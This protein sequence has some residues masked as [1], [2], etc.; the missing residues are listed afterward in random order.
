MRVEV[1]YVPSDDS[2]P[3]VIEEDSFS[4]APPHPPRLQRDGR[5]YVF[6]RW[7]LTWVGGQRRTRLYYREREMLT[8]VSRNERRAS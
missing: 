2:L 3:H 4:P 1:V 7:E 8:G 5:D 6:D